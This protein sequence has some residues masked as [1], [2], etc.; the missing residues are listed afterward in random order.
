MSTIATSSFYQEIVVKVVPARPTTP[1]VAQ[2]DSFS[3]SSKEPTRSYDALIYTDLNIPWLTLPVSPLPSQPQVVAGLSL[4]GIEH[5]VVR[6]SRF[7]EYLAAFVEGEK[8]PSLMRSRLFETLSPG[9]EMLFNG[10][11]LSDQPV[12]VWWSSETPELED[13][14]WELVAYAERRYVGGLFSFV[15]GLPPES[16]VPKVPVTERLRLAFIH[17]LGS[18]NEWLR[19]TLG[20]LSPSIIEVIPMTGPPREALL[21]AAREGYELVHIVADGTISLAYEGILWLHD[22]S[23]PQLAP[24]ELSALLSGSRVRVLGL[25]ERMSSNPDRVAIGSYLVP[26]AYRAF[27]YL[28]NSRLPLP[29]IV[30]PVG[31]LNGWQV[32]QFWSNFYTTLATTLEI[33]EAMAAGRSSGS[34]SMALFLRQQHKSTFQRLAP[35]YAATYVNPAQIDADLQVSRGMVEQLRTVGTKYGTLP[36][37]VTQFIEQESVRQEQLVAELSPWTQE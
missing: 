5:L 23:I 3:S 9:L 18:T 27:V 37:S 22:P 33:E 24:S 17:E 21:E 35:A 31:P 13:L 16:L 4:A 1:Q 10:Q 32:N 15:R 20:T 6:W 19:S 36:E 29:N 12:R 11:P 30:A 28:S 7:T 34:A 2:F 25:T 8:A 26:S 14:P